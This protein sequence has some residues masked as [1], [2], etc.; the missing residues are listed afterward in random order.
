MSKHHPRRYRR[1]SFFGT[2][3]PQQKGAGWGRGAQQQQQKS[4]AATATAARVRGNEINTA[5]RDKV[6]FAPADLLY[7]ESLIKST[8]KLPLQKS[9]NGSV[10]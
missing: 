2:S 7:S 1:F 9:P 5:K 3:L 4:A 10:L 6:G 8:K